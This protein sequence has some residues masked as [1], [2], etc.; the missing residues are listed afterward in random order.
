M[1]VGRVQLLTLLPWYLNVNGPV[2]GS[3]P[4][5]VVGIV[6]VGTSMSMVG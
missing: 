4:G 3:W 1:G 6:H 5:I 2:G